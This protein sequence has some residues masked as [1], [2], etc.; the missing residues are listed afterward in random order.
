MDSSLVVG[1]SEKIGCIEEAHNVFD[2]MPQR[3]VISWNGIIFG[4]AKCGRMEDVH[5]VFDEMPERNVIL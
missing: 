2:E 4:Y 5:K 1:I 3:D